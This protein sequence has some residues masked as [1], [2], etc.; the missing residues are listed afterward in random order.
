RAPRDAR[1]PPGAAGHTRLTYGGTWR[2]RTGSRLS[3]P[4]R[5]RRE[6]FAEAADDRLAS[7][8]PAPLC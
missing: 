1:H 7:V 6:G 8:V 2:K 5:T 4:G 3:W